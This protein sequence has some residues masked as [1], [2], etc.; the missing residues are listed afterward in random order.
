MKFHA[1][2]WAV[3]VTA[4]VLGLG[5]M[6]AAEIGSGQ[7][8]KDG[9]LPDAE[10]AKMLKRS[11]KGIQDALKGTPEEP[12][13]EKARTAA[14]MT[15]AYAQDNLNGADGQQRATVR[16]AALKVAELIKAKKYADASKLAGTL[17]T[18]EA[19]PKAKKEKVKLIDVHLTFS[20]L[21]HQFRLKPDG[22]WGIFGHLQ[23]IQTKK[24][25]MMPREELND[26]FVLE[27]YQ[28]AVAADLLHGHMHKAKPK[29]WGEY[30]DDM[31]KF[32]I[33]LGEKLRAKDAKAS[34]EALSRL[35]TT[36]FSCHKMLKVK[37]TGN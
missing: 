29:E 10:Y 32:A 15:A 12:M 36:C 35:T 25:T 27:A 31:K 4:M 3:R 24:P 26:N 11:V 30:T 8:A 9:T 18:L 1:R 14:V 28:V 5:I 19:D 34:P 37:N 16:D 2:G 6:A 21:M 23:E 33:D 22:G 7:G 20:D 17:P 13:I